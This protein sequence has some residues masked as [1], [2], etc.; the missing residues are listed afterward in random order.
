MKWFFLLGD[1]FL[2]YFQQTICFSQILKLFAN[3]PMKSFS[4]VLN[5][6]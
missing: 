6:S 1:P 5:L 3:K 2:K 4:M